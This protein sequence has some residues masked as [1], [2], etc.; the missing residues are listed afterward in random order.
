MSNRRDSGY[1]GLAVI[2]KGIVI[3]IFSRSCCQPNVFKRDIRHLPNETDYKI[4]FFSPPK[5]FFPAVI[6]EENDRDMER[7]IRFLKRRDVIKD[8]N[9]SKCSYDKTTSLQVSL[10]SGCDNS[11]KLFSTQNIAME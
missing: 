11:E 6:N 8:K 3:I 10:E 2:N 1:K 9:P 5:I 4:P 7:I